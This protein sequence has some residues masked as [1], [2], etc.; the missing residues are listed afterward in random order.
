MSNRTLTRAALLLVLLALTVPTANV[1]ALNGR[2]AS[3]QESAQAERKHEGAQKGT[4]YDEAGRVVKM[5]VPTSEKDKVTVR[6]QYDGQNKIE[7]VVLDD[8]T[9][10]GMLYD[11]SGLWQGCSFADGGKMLFKRDASGKING[12]RRVAGKARQQSRDARGETL[13]R[14]GLGAP[15]VVDDCAEATLA[16]VGA[17]A[18]AVAICALGPSL[19]CVAARA[20]A[21]VAVKKAY[22]ACKNSTIAAEESAV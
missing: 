12:L 8:G 7:S 15:L 5:T 17:T 10:I 1:A 11:A 2:R 20:A 13:Q 4:T 18:S 21:A 9:Q 14:V 16:A 22:D 3:A 19:E 6:L